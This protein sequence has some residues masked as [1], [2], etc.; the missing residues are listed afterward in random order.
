[1]IVAFVDVISLLKQTNLASAQVFCH[2]WS[3]SYKKIFTETQTKDSFFG[4][5]ASL[6]VISSLKQT[7]LVLVLFYFRAY[8][9]GYRNRPH[10]DSSLGQLFLEF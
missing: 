6:S 3:P 4:V 5:V 9:L 1:V 8:F 10:W 7:D 2:A